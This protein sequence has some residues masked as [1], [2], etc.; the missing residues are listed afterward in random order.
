MHK[1]IQKRKVLSQQQ[2]QQQLFAGSL[3]CLMYDT[4]HVIHYCNNNETNNNIGKNKGIVVYT[5]YFMNKLHI[6]AGA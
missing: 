5:L 1:K 3:F 4:F 6:R 2:Q